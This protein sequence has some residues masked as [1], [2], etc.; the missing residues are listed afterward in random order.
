M[1]YGEDVPKTKHLEHLIDKGLP[2]LDSALRWIFFRL[3]V[4][5]G[6]V[7]T[8]WVPTRYKWS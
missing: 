1:F 2:A 6:K 4:A 7:Y 3:P 5:N 8:K